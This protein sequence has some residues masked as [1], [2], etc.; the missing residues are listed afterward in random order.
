M[1]MVHSM[2]LDNLMSNRLVSTESPSTAPTSQVGSR[3][4]GRDF[5]EDNLESWRR[6]ARAIIP[7]VIQLISPNSVVDVGCGIGIWLSVFAENGVNDLRGFDGEYIE[8][9]RLL[10][11]RAHFV[12]TDLSRPFKIDRRYDLS[13]CLEVAEHLPESS[14]TGLVDAL[15][16]A[17]SIVL[18]SAAPPG[19]G[20][21]EHINE[22]WPWYWQKLFE[23]RGYQMFD[24]IR[25][26]IRDD[27]SIA[28]WYRQNI[29]LFANEE[30]LRE[31]PDLCRFRRDGQGRG[32]EWMYVDVYTSIQDSLSAAS[33]P[34]LR[35]LVKEFP[36]AFKRTVSRYLS[37]SKRS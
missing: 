24:P 22:Q 37:P 1:K 27:E 28:W 17:S 2:K 36:T 16:G 33:N 21:V 9:Q 6:S 12:A 4:Y 5:F 3:P 30:G 11:D 19:Q 14:G 13:V 15:T 31:H 35:R 23:K 34:G 32:I 10:I 7:K 18:F 8:H 20:G 26:Q 25:P 29:V